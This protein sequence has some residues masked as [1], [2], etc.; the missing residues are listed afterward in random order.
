MASA[1]LNGYRFVAI[2]SSKRYYAC[3]CQQIYALGSNDDDRYR[4]SARH[5]STRTGYSAGLRPVQSTWTVSRLH[6]KSRF[7]HSSTLFTN[8]NLYDN[9]LLKRTLHFTVVCAKEESAIEKALKNL[10]DVA[11]KDKGKPKSNSHA[12]V[13]HS[14]FRVFV[15]KIYTKWTKFTTFI[16]E[17]G[18]RGVL[19]HMWEEMKFYKDGFKLFWKD[20]RICIPLS[21]KYLTKGRSS[22][23]RREYRLLKQTLVDLLL[24]FPILPT[25]IIPFM[26]VLI[27]VF[28]WIG[29]IP[30]VFVSKEARDTKIRAKLQRKI[31]SAKLLVD[32]LNNMPLRSKSKKDETASTFQEFT[33]FMN[34]VRSS[35]MI[36]SINEI[37]K[38]SRFFENSLTLDDL[39]VKQL[40]GLCKLLGIGFLSDIPSARV[41]RFQIDTR[42]RELTV[43]DKFILRD[44]IDS[45]TTE[46]LQSANRARGMRA[47]GVSE[48]QLRIQLQHWL[49]LHLKEQVPT[50]LL[51]LSR[52]MYID[53]SLSP[54]EQLRQ[55][56]S[57]LPE[58]TV[59]KVK[60]TSAETSGEKVD[61]KT[62]I[63]VLEEETKAIEMENLQVAEEKRLAKEK[64]EAHQ[65]QE[66][67]RRAAEEEE[68]RKLAEITLQKMETQ[69]IVQEVAH[70]L[71]TQREKVE[72]D[73]VKAK[74]EP[75][76]VSE[77]AVAETVVSKEPVEGEKDITE[78]V[79]PEP[80]IAEPIIEKPS[81]EPADIAKK[82]EDE[83]DITAQD[84]GDIEKAIEEQAK[85][86]KDEIAEV[87]EELD[88]YKEDVQDIKALCMK[89]DVE[90]EIEE[91]LNAKILLK[92]L[93]KLMNKFDKTIEKL[94]DEK[95][96]I[97]E[98]IDKD[99]V[100]LKYDLDG[101][102]EE[103]LEEISEKK[104][105]LISIN[106][107]LLSLKRLQKVPDDVRMQKVLEILDTDKDGHIDVKQVLKVT[108]SL[109]RENLKL[110][111]SQ[112]EA[113]IKLVA[114]EE[115]LEMEEKIKE[116][117]EKEKELSKNQNETQAEE[118]KDKQAA[119]S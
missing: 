80:D 50:S 98:R 81:E 2:Q 58:T 73:A 59:D 15:T 89:T 18:I 32:S 119:G 46:E 24:M 113:M 75:E 70:R 114:K 28:L 3:G 104:S 106:D 26:E 42:M 76:A 60:V 36:P 66:E 34:K 37:L 53:E 43:D 9:C 94:Q 78:D 116:K 17:N 69:R 102:H 44:G 117:E 22:L 65:L 52:V 51:L 87:A 27:P 1:L 71:Q 93:D 25:L 88:E 63:K 110:N 64:L 82:I 48:E 54:A 39:N 91:T 21:Y 79:K 57:A 40:Q 68:K 97:Q 77:A 101:K 31:E 5:N 112:V 10:K 4:N 13:P 83:E 14:K 12:L 99:E 105:N 7:M 41:L 107:V 67:E 38:F 108:E 30:Q 23:T 56:I 19:K 45:L 33:D 85:H 16:K 115:A 49:E 86:Y 47:L 103:I 118:S 20:L 6:C 62:K 35:D 61:K 96:E 92:R 109:G 55:T 111:K 11:D 90:K 95:L 72:A 29:M 74:R 100:T 8:L 84:L